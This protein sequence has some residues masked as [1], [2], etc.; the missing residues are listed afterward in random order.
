MARRTKPST[1]PPL[2]PQDGGAVVLSG[3][4]VQGPAGP[5]GER[6]GV[7]L[8]VDRPLVILVDSRAIVDVARRAILAE[9]RDQLYDGQTPAG[10]PQRPLSQRALGDPRRVSD[11]RG[12]RTGHMADEMRATPIKGD[13]AR[14]ES[15]VLPPTDRNVFVATEL[16]RGVRYL[17]LGPRHLAASQRAV[18]E[19]VKAMVEGR[20]VEPEQGEPKAE[21]EAKG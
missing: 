19:A 4:G 5:K 18:D 21:E 14:A 2:K 16:K 8:E 6:A 9:V 11:K 10:G 1:A 13:T 7:S 3:A 15:V 17:G 12:V 20:K